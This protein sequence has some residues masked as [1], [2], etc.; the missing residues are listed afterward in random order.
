MRAWIFLFRTGIIANEQL[1]ELFSGLVPLGHRVYPGK[2]EY[3]KT[4]V[5][6][7]NLCTIVVGEQEPAL[8]IPC[9]VP[10]PNMV[11]LGKLHGVHILRG[12]VR[13]VEVEKGVGP[14][15]VVDEGFKVLVF[16]YHICQPVF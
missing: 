6:L 8:H 4:V 11:G 5:Q 12:E 3:W 7:P 16:D 15:V 2:I 13:R 10:Q 9:Y 1:L 14:V